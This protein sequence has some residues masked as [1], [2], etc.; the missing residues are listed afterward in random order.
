MIAG[1]RARECGA[2]RRPKNRK[3]LR[4]PSADV[5]QEAYRNP[6]APANSTALVHYGCIAFWLAR[7]RPARLESTRYPGATLHH[8]AAALREAQ[9][10]KLVASRPVSADLGAGWCR[11]WA[12]PATGLQFI[13]EISAKRTH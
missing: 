7:I 1:D 8:R 9:A 10:A 4:G 3:Y 2:L 13:P 11:W 12:S 5:D 6:A